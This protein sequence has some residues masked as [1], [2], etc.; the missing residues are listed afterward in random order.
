MFIH[1]TTRKALRSLGL[2][3]VRFMLVGLMVLLPTQLFASI[4]PDPPI[5]TTVISLAGQYA[6]V[7]D[8]AQITF[9]TL[10]PILSGGVFESPSE[11]NQQLGYDLSRQW[12]VGQTADTYLKLGDFQTSLYPQIFNLHTIAQIANLDLEQVALSAFK[13][14]TWQT[15]DDLVTA[16]PG[17]GGYEVADIPVIADLL[18]G[19]GS[20]FPGTP[21]FNP[22]TTLAEVLNVNPNLGQ[23]SLGELGEQLGQF[24]ITDIPGLENVPLQNLRNW[25]DSFIRDVPG[26][27]DI[28]LNQMPNPIANLGIMGVVDMVY[29]PAE[30]DRRNTISGGD[31]V[32]FSATCQENCAHV[33]LTGNP[34][35]HGKQ[36]IS[37][38]YQDVKGG[39]GVLRAANG[40]KEP[41]GRH[42]FGK[43]F[44]L[45]VWDVDESTGSV[46]TALH[47]RICYRGIPISAAPL[48]SWV[49]FRPQLPGN[50]THLC[51]IVRPSGRRLQSSR[52]SGGRL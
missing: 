37:G 40:G 11:I 25:G 3:L 47:F 2:F 1:Y 32:G 8:W 38:K 41:T 16:I 42:P 6:R 15:L 19:H 36:W 34:T 52:R 27:A 4:A 21:P 10:P 13:T 24:A 30:Q 50:R 35:L 12:E 26:L 14:V 31:Q 46:S 44:K 5:P 17:L 49:R 43:A 22:N 48:I 45:S 51:G 39:F 18:R 28:P 9:R 29:G 20:R 23:L 33:E 7:P